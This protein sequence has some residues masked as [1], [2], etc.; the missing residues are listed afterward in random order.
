MADLTFSQ[1]EQLWIGAG[2]L[3]SLAPLMAPIA[4]AESSGNPNAINPDD[5]DGKQSSFGLW[6]ISNGTHSPPAANWA[7]PQENASLAVAK[8]KS[9]GLDAWGTYVSGAYEK[10]LAAN[11]VSGNGIPS[12]YV[13]QPLGSSS[14]SGPLADVTSA[15]SQAGTLLGDSA[16]ALDWFFHF[17]KPG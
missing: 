15:G 6:Q 7:N 9:Q 4:L 11:G 8:W 2:G 14:S 5:N 12:N 16:K 10:Y 13:Q 17:F 3:K 1:L